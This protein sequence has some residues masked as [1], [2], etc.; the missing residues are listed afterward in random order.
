MGQMGNGY[1]SECHLLRYLG[2][3]REAL[4]AAIRATV[5]CGD[6]RWLD[7]PFDPA[8]DWKDAEW[9]GLEF[10]PSNSPAR[11]AWRRAW[12]QRGNPPN[13]D[14]IGQVTRNGSSEWL[15]VEAKAHTGE[16]QSSCGA[17]DG[18]AR[19]LIQETLNATKRRLAVAEEHD[20][21]NGYYQLCNRLAVLN[22]LQ[23]AGVPARLL[24][25]YFTGDDFGRPGNACPQSEAEWQPALEDQARHV[26]LPKQ[27]PLADRIHKLF[28]P[29]CP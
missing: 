24:F 16:I 3:H 7:C 2:R 8:S 14:A 9:K 13:W 11:E 25:I 22:I 12:P 4:N 17:K 15:L 1:G 29:V 26:G 5:G 20:W 28:L 19:Q 6:V 23:E 10:L 21:M 27:H 18:P